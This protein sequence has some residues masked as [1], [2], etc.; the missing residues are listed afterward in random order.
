MELEKREVAG[1]QRML[2]IL[3]AGFSVD[4]IHLD[5]LWKKQLSSKEFDSYR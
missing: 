1:I 2:N 4:K 3:I 5:Y